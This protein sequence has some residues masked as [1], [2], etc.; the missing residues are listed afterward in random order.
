M[1]K[2]KI[3]DIVFGNTYGDI[4]VQYALGNTL[5]NLVRTLSPETIRTEEVDIELKVNGVE[6]DH[7]EFFKM[8]SEVYFKKVNSCAVKM[9][10]NNMESFQQSLRCLAT[11]CVNDLKDKVDEAFDDYER[12]IKKEWDSHTGE[13][14]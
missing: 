11:Q 14:L 9:F 12:E 4:A 1:A 7:E 5:D 8:L 3:K 13:L 10:K 6:V 2:R